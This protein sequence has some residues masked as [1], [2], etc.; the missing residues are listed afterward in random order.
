MSPNQN[1]NCHHFQR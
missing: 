1:Q